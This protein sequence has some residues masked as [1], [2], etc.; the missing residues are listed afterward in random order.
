MDDIAQINAF[1]GAYG[2]TILFS[3]VAALI[4]WLFGCRA[5]RNATNRRRRRQWAARQSSMTA[6]LALHW[7]EFE[8]FTGEVFRGLGYCVD[9]TGRDG[10]DGGMDL[11]LRKGGRKFIVQCKHYRARQVGVQIVREMAGVSV[12]EKANGAIIVTV[13]RFTRAARAD[14]AAL[15]VQLV[16]GPAL[17]RLMRRRSIT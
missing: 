15:A 11:I 6:L 7:S 17:L 5:V 9:E 2:F 10:P 14:A 13:G 16:D 3:T 8:T 12:R 4:A 1:V